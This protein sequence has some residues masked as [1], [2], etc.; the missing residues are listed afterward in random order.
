M[1]PSKTRFVT[2]CQQ[3][4]AL[5]VGARRAH[6]GRE[7]HQPGRGPA[8]ARRTPRTRRPATRGATLAAYTREAQPDVRSCP[9]APV[10]ADVDEYPL[11]AGARSARPRRARSAPGPRSARSAATRW[12]AAAEPVTG[13]GAVGVT[14]DA[15]RTRSRATTLTLQVRTRTDGT[16]S[17][18]IELAVPRRPRPRPGQRRG[19]GTPARAP[20]CCS[21]AR[22][23][24]CRSARPAPTARQPADMR[25]AVI[26]PGTPSATARELPA[27]ETD[28]ERRRRADRARPSRVPS[29]P[30]DDRRRGR[31]GAV[32]PRRT[33]RSR[34]STRAPSG[35][36]T[37]GCATRARC[38]TSRCTPGSCTTR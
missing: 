15:R 26:D 30:A 3:L 36:P 4:L 31:T 22:S 33:R 34:R 14:W 21:S 27:I 28:D 23:T 5:G 8:D 20:T 38:T 6:P 1:R 11:T 29:E 24:R 32:R 16:W 10:E 17:D 37:S 25:L 9:T 35:A 19:A 18:W 2:A 7:R 12:S 13:Y